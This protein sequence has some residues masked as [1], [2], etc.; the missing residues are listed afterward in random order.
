LLFAEPLAVAALLPTPASTV[1][2]R[3]RIPAFDGAFRRVTT[4]ALQE[5]LDPFSTT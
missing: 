1:H 5:E 4:I 2:A 3:S